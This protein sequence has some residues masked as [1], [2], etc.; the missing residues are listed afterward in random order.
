MGDW[1][2]IRVGTPD[3]RQVY[4]MSASLKRSLDTVLGKLVRWWCWLDDNGEEGY[5]DMTPAQVDGMLGCKG[6]TE[7]MLAVGWASLAEDGTVFVE[8]FDEFNGTEAK[9][10]AM[11]ARRKAAGRARQKVA[12]GSAEGEKC[13]AKNVTGVTQKTGQVSRKKRDTSH[14]ESVTSSLRAHARVTSNNYSIKEKTTLTSSLKESLRPAS[15]A[16]VEK[17]ISQDATI[18]LCGSELS[19]CAA[20]FLDGMESVGWRN[21]AGQDITDWTAAARAYARRWKNNLL[22]TGGNNRRKD[23]NEPSDYA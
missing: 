13:H 12:D 3:K 18:G 8:H 1:I 7:A 10:R 23:C 6:F 2:Q 16:E 17:I 5:T 15:A 20:L 19:R 9:N 11:A 14:G 21:K 22:A 4:A